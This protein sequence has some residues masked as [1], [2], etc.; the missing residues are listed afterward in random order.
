M[1]L[2]ETLIAPL[3]SKALEAG[4]SDLILTAELKP[5]L[6]KYKGG[7]QEYTDVDGSEPLSGDDFNNVV[8][9][10]RSTDRSDTAEIMHDG[11]EFRYAIIPGA[12]LFRH[13]P[14]AEQLKSDMAKLAETLKAKYPTDATHE[15]LRSATEVFPDGKR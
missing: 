3:L 13:L 8:R 9:H 5:Q 2:H 14:S 11:Q 6:M 4:A 12:V 1:T 15:G 10:L 7:F